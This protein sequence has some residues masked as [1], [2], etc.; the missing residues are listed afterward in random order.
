MHYLINNEKEEEIVD[1]D[2]PEEE[3][4]RMRNDP[5]LRVR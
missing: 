4:Y 2:D 5:G 1:I 3:A